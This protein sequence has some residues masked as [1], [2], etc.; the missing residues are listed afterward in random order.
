MN[1][2]VRIKAKKYTYIEYRA[3]IRHLDMHILMEKIIIL[4]TWIV[5]VS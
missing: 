3:I 1:E 2:I 4:N 5:L